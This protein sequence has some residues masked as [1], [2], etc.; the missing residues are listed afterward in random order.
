MHRV[1][2]YGTLKQK[3]PNSH[4]MSSEET[5]YSKFIG[6]ARLTQKYPLLVS[7][8]FNIPF[9]LNNPGV[10]QFVEGE[11]YEV[12]DKKLIALDELENHPHFYVRTQ[13][14]I[15]FLSNGEKTD[16][17]VYLLPAWKETLVTSGT[18][19]L[20][21]YSTNGPHGRP[22]LESR[23]RWLWVDHSW[24]LWHLNEQNGYLLN[25]CSKKSRLKK[26]GI[27]HKE[28]YKSP[29]KSQQ[30]TF[31][32]FSFRP[33]SPQ[34]AIFPIEEK[35]KLLYRQKK[36]R[37]DKRFFHIKPAI[38]K[39]RLQEQFDKHEQSRKIK[40][41]KK[42]TSDDDLEEWRESVFNHEIVWTREVL[43]RVFRP[44]YCSFWE[45]DEFVLEPSSDI[46]MFEEED[47][48]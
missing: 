29:D 47:C 15:E 16:I 44:S 24:H 17:F 34:A 26:M 21:T 20:T 10:G 33:S 45:E 35:Q 37:V 11:V 40:P 30:T 38:E 14:Q 36:A 3:E 32:N 31:E 39:T 27:Q 1:F 13:Q 28:R 9:L 5:G 12:D 48:F 4:V 2:V 7:T 43:K 23:Q 6:V 18:E 41:I 22:Y 46:A 8:Q 25:G 42:S 19:F